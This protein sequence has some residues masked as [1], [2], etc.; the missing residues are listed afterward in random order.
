MQVIKTEKVNS[1]NGWGFGGWI[2]TRTYYD[3][4]IILEKGKVYYRHAPPNA[5]T[6]IKVAV[7]EDFNVWVEGCKGKLPT[8]DV[9]IYNCADREYLAILGECADIRKKFPYY[10]PDEV[11]LFKVIKI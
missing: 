2:G 3:N 10:E 9:Y 4:G 1:N 7:N 11:K 5:F 6:S 8:K